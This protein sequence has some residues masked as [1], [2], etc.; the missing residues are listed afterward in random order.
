MDAPCTGRLVPCTTSLCPHATW[1]SG[2][3]VNRASYA[4]RAGGVAMINA[5]SLGVFQSAAYQF[6]ALTTSYQFSM[7]RVM[8]LGVFGPVRRVLCF[9]HE[10]AHSTVNGPGSRLRHRDPHAFAHAGTSTCA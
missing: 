5:N 4:G 8:A 10:N 1:I 3:G 2:V 7:S 6:Q 9:R